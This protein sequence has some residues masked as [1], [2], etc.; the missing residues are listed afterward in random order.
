MLK[1]SH[2]FLCSLVQ[3]FDLNKNDWA[4]KNVEMMGVILYTFFKR[5]T[6]EVLKIKITLVTLRPSNSQM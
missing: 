2:L 1:I 6:Q 5:F 4:L 3:N